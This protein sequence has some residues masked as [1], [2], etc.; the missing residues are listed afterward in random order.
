[1]L[2]ALGRLLDLTRQGLQLALELEA[3]PRNAAELKARLVELGLNPRYE[4]WL[5]SNRS[6][7]VSYTD[8]FVRVHRGYLGAPR[9]VHAAIVAFVGPS[10]RKIRLAAK[11][12][13]LAYRLD[14]PSVRQTRRHATR[15]HEDDVRMAAK[16]VEHHRRYNAEK[17]G[18]ELAD[19]PIHISRRMRT[20]LG[21]YTHR[22]GDGKG[23][24]IVVS[25]RHIRRHGWGEALETLLH[26][27]VHQWQDEKGMAIDHGRAFRVQAR[28]I[29][30]T[31][32]ARRDVA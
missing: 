3:S 5:T 16:L 7:V 23:A 15:T 2:R 32:L 10:P 27:M 12:E 1:M 25:R 14:H 11:R 28:T 17:F 9:H 29:G 31:P 21:H 22:D 19:I 20:K 13:L 18:G 24:E 6:V 30:I 8:R 26:E 4:L